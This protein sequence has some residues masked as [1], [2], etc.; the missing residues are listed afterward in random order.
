MA[1]KEKTEPQDSVEAAKR[2]IKEAQQKNMAE[3]AAE[4]K[5]LLTR[6]EMTLKIFSDIR[7]VNGKLQDHSYITI[8]PAPAE[9]N[10]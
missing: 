9:Q 2:L 10:N 6:R 4:L 7:F 8:V 3:T 5:D 1:K